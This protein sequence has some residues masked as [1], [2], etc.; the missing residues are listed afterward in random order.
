MLWRDGDGE[1]GWGSMM[2]VGCLQQHW[3]VEMCGD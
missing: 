2:D 1:M 3:S